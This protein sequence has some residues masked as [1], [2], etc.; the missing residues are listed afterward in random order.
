MLP[1]RTRR[2]RARRPIAVKLLDRLL[3]RGILPRYAFPTDVATFHVFDQARSSRF[4][5][6]MRFAPSQGLPIAL[7]Q[8][9]PGKQIWISGKCYSSGAIYSVMPS[10][11]FAAWEAKRLYCECSA[12]GFARTYEIGEISRGD[13]AGLSGL[14][15]EKH[16]R[17]SAVLAAA[18]GICASRRCRG[19]HLAR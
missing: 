14:R 19:G 10:D 3:Y 18:A 7:I 12:C 13:R 16:L 11:R 15:D 6:I 2:T 4:R 17:R 5:P 9:A 1:K 8:Y